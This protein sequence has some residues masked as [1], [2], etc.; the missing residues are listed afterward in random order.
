[1]PAANDI[2]MAVADLPADT[3]AAASVAV[4]YD[5]SGAAWRIK[6]ILWRG[7]HGVA[8][9][10]SMAWRHPLTY[11]RHDRG[12]RRDDSMIFIVAMSTMLICCRDV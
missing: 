2:I 11:R 5:I 9:L 3:V 6:R 1:M 7:R 10:I 8:K 4:A 12:S